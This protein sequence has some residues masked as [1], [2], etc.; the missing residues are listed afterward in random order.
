MPCR[1]KWRIIAEIASC[2][3]E[4]NSPVCEIEICI[5]KITRQPEAAAGRVNRCVIEVLLDFY[6]HL[7]KREFD[8]RSN[9]VKYLSLL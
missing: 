4:R 7:Q 2:I 8:Q 9:Q 6:M 3:V 1:R 5:L